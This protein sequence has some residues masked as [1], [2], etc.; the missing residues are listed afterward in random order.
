MKIADE[1]ISAI[2]S[3]GYTSDEA[4][5]LYIVAT[6]SGYFVPRQFI[7]FTGASWGKR[8]QHFTEK[9]A[10]YCRPPAAS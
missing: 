5:F 10:G 2:Q 8:S 4:R 9:I 1:H 7:T 6:H 3:L